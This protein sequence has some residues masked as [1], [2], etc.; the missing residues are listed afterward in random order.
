[1]NYEHTLFVSVEFIKKTEILFLKRYNT[2]IT[3]NRITIDNKHKEANS[4]FEINEIV[5]P[6]VVA[7]QEIFI[8]RP[9]DCLRGDFLLSLIPYIIDHFSYNRGGAG[10]IVCDKNHLTRPEQS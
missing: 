4:T 10:G 7:D 5:M 6:T 9:I 8:R 1:M 3:N 2:C